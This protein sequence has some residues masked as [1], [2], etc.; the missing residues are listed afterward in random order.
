MNKKTT[1]EMI[2][3]LYVNAYSKSEALEYGEDLI[4][5]IDTDFLSALIEKN[6]LNEIYLNGNFDIFVN[7]AISNISDI[8]NR[9]IGMKYANE[10]NNSLGNTKH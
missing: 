10:N 3:Q 8:N 6:D 1:Y 4:A 5:S 7:P 9:F 2:I